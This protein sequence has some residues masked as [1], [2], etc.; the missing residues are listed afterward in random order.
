MNIPK[1][2]N[3]SSS[4]EIIKFSKLVITSEIKNNKNYGGTK[5]IKNQVNFITP[6]FQVNI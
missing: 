5:I 2:R 6:Y 1:L 3:E 4:E